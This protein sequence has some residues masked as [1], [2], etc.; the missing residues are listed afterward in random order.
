MY[1]ICSGREQA[2]N[3]KGGK[4]A[5]KGGGRHERRDINQG[6]PAVLLSIYKLLFIHLLVLQPPRYIGKLDCPIRCA[7]EGLY[8]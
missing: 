2:K 7:R 4:K 8:R 3:I 1:H 5:G 6:K